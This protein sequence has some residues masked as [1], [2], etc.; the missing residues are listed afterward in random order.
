MER[1]PQ[2]HMRFGVTDS[3]GK[4]EMQECT[5]WCL[6]CKL[7]RLQADV[8]EWKS[9]E[10]KA[11]GA[12]VWLAQIH[13]HYGPHGSILDHFQA[14]QYDEAIALIQ[15]REQ[16]RLSR[17]GRAIISVVAVEEN[18]HRLDCGDE[19]TAHVWVS[20]VTWNARRAYLSGASPF[21]DALRAAS[22]TEK[23]PVDLL[24][25]RFIAEL[26]IDPPDD[27]PEPGEW[28]QWPNLE[29][30]PSMDEI[31]NRPGIS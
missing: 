2:Q 24:N 31:R 12:C 28:L 23:A 27:E 26:P 7:E 21:L 8:N 30:A 6:A 29:L 25:E 14:G 5:D 19:E 13:G 17:T 3:E 22:G 11:R 20:V 15:T 18:R 1:I 9:W 16:R 4:T 10:A